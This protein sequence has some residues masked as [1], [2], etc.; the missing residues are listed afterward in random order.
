M[1]SERYYRMTVDLEIGTDLHAG[2]AVID[3]YKAGN[4]APMLVISATDDP[5]LYEIITKALMPW[6]IPTS[7]W[8]R[9]LEPPVAFAAVSS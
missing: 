5:V 6:T 9:R 1:Q 8:R 3:A 2:I 4:I 7:P